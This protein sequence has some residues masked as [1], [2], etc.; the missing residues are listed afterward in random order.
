M[1]DKLVI[2]MVSTCISILWTILWVTLMWRMSRLD[3]N[4]KKIYTMF[5]GLDAKYVRI[6][7]C[8]EKMKKAPLK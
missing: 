6:A 1:E 2:L 7:L 3:E 5:E 8:D 4:I